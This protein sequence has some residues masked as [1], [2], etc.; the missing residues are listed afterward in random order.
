M[1]QRHARRCPDDNST[2][3]RNRRSASTGGVTWPDMITTRHRPHVPSPPHTAAR[4]MPACRAA[5]SSVEPLATSTRLPIGSKSI[6]QFVGMLAWRLSCKILVT[7]RPAGRDDDDLV[8]P[9]AID[10][11]LDQRSR[12][13]NLLVAQSEFGAGLPRILAV[14]FE[15]VIARIDKSQA[16]IVFQCELDHAVGFLLAVPL[17]QFSVFLKGAVADLD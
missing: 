2:C 6:W 15:V 14:P 1:W 5:S 7:D 12:A 13:F 17:D 4:P 11:F 16:G 10:H 8:I 9:R 3:E